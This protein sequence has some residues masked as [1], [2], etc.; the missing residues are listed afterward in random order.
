MTSLLIFIFLFR[1][2]VVEM[3]CAW[4]TLATNDGYAMGALVLAH[5]LKAVNTVHKLHCMVTPQVSDPVRENLHAV[6]DEVSLV[7]VLDSNDDV[8]LALIGRPDLGVTFTKLHCWRLTQYEKCVFLDADVL[9]V[10]NADELFERPEF[11]AAADIGWPDYF[12]SGVFVFKPSTGTYRCLLEFAVSDG[13]FD[14]GDQGLLN[15]FFAN[16]RD[17]DSAHRL[18]FIYNMTAGAIYSYAAAYKRQ[19]A[20]VKIVHFIGTEKPWNLSP[21][22]HRSEH[23]DQWQAIFHSKVSPHVPRHSFVA[24]SENLCDLT[25][26]QPSNAYEPSEEERLSAWETG[27]P[28]YLGRDAFSNIQKML[29]KALEE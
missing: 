8:N 23:V 21:S 18:P 25:P 16:W 9:V 4:V 20:N 13:S 3:P 14:G 7:N 17:M 11:S 15:Q 22:A 26:N 2:I 19:S 5:S 24:S 6:F 10:Q 1:Q 27:N 29:E 28:D 12:N